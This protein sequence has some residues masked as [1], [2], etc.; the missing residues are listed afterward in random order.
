MGLVSPKSTIYKFLGAV[1]EE[2]LKDWEHIFMPFMS[3]EQDLEGLLS[4]LSRVH[5]FFS[6]FV[7]RTG[8]SSSIF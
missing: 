5:S 6:I 8:T 7:L 3:R 2:A 1:R 4:V